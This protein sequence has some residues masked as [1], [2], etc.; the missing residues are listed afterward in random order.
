M[1][2]KLNLVRGRG[3]EIYTSKEIKEEQTEQT[4][5]DEEAT[6]EDAPV[7]LITHVKIIWHSFFSNVEV[8]FNNQQVCNSNGVYAHKSYISEHLKEAIF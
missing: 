7:P 4:K 2:L 5:A 3:Y 6:A 1:S 8:Y